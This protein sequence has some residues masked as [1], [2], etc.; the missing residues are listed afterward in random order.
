MRIGYARVFSAEQNLDLQTGAL[1]AA[2]YGRIYEEHANGKN[3][4]RTELQNCLKA[5]RAGDVL[6]VWRLDRLGHDLPDLVLIVGDLEASKVRL[7]SITVQIET[8]S[9]TGKL[10]SI[11]SPRWL[12]SNGT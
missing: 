6:V 5:L 11:S 8:V 1:K 10:V 9:Y 7:E 3:A 12:S 4:G 2:W